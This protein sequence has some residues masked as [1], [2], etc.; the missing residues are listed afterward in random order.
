MTAV[1]IRKAYASVHKYKWF[2]SCVQLHCPCCPNGVDGTVSSR[3]VL[4]QLGTGVGWGLFLS[5]ATKV[6]LKCLIHLYHEFKIR[7]STRACYLAVMIYWTLWS[8]YFMEENHLGHQGKQR[9]RIRG[10]FSIFIKQMSLEFKAMLQIHEEESLHENIHSKQPIS[11]QSTWGR[12]TCQDDKCICCHLR[13]QI[14]VSSNCPFSTPITVVISLA[15][16]NW[17]RGLFPQ[18][19]LHLGFKS[20]SFV[21]D[22]GSNCKSL[23]APFICKVLYY[24][25]SQFIFLYK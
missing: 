13:T 17:P 14:W 5:K 4:I 3:S 12:L 7:F 9:P 20:C 15:I 10:L 8:C 24:H 6:L 1:V 2:C 16:L 23:L 21:L 11:G 18:Q 25:Y 19:S 22:R